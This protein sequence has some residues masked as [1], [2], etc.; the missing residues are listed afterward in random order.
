KNGNSATHYLIE[1]TNT[2]HTEMPS[3]Q[4]AIGYVKTFFYE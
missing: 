2:E 4:K 1:G 3:N